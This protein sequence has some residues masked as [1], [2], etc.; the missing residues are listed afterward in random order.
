MFLVSNGARGKLYGDGVAYSAIHN[1]T[2]FF[3]G[4]RR[5]DFSLFCF[6]GEARGV[7]LRGLKY[8]LC[9]AV[10]RSD[11]PIGVSNS[12]TGVPAEVTV[13][14]GTLIIYHEI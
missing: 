7:T 1:E 6:D 13:K 8:P 2:V 4:G 5:G 14:D 3:D 12:F 11:F 9:D 10:I